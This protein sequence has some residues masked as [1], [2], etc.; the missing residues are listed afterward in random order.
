MYRSKYKKKITRRDVLK[1]AAAAAAVP[2]A[3]K[4]PH[5]EVVEPHDITANDMQLISA[6][7]WDDDACCTVSYATVLRR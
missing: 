1:G 3:A 7:G 2:V 6:A 5:Q 4:I